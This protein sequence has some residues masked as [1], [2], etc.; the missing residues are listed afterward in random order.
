MGG[1]EGTAGTGP[2]KARERLRGEGAELSWLMR[3]TYIAAEANAERKQAAADADVADPA[4]PG[5]DLDA[6]IAEIEV[7]SAS[8]V[9]G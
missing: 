8:A 3:T 1:A 9:P 5:V 4:A 6:Q 2:G 7:R